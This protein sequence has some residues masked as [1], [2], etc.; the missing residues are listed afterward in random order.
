MSIGLTFTGKIDGPQALLEAA[1]VLVDQR[2]YRLGAGESGLRIGMC[3]LA[4][5]GGGGRPLAGTGGVYLYPGGGGAAP[6]CGGTAGQSAH[7]R[8]GGAG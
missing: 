3:P 5:R 6:G 2:N 1:R 7:P 8:A 4:A